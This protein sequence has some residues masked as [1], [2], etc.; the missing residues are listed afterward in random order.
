ME[1]DSK[2]AEFDSTLKSIDRKIKEGNVLGHNKVSAMAEQFASKD[3]LASS[4]SAATGCSPSTALTPGGGGGSG[5]SGAS[6]DSSKVHRSV[7]I[8]WQL[9]RERD[10]I[11][12]NPYCV[13]YATL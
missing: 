12:A 4:A 6:V 5:G 10:R 2:Y 1:T 13:C 8:L 11:T 9:Q 3:A 7:I